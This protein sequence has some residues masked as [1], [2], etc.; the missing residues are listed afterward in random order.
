VTAALTTA[1]TA[2]ATLKSRMTVAVVCCFLLRIFQDLVS[3]VRFFE[4]LFGLWI[5]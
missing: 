1:T 3:F 4:L 2:H 5:V